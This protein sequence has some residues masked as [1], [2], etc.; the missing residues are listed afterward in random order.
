LDRFKKADEKLS[1]KYKK[2]QQTR[3]S[4]EMNGLISPFTLRDQ[5]EQCPSTPSDSGAELVEVIP[6]VSDNTIASDLEK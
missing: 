2:D 3:T 1:K 4:S 5:D 6:K